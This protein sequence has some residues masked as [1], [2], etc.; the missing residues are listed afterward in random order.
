V[1]VEDGG[2]V[3]TQARERYQSVRDSLP[4]LGYEEIAHDGGIHMFRLDRTP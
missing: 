4:S 1:V 2:P 3:S